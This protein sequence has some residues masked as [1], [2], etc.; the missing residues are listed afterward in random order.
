MDA[1]SEHLVQKA[2]DELIKLGLQTVICIAHRLSTIRDADVIMVMKYGEIVER[3]SH[4]ELM[5]IEDGVYKALIS[6]QLQGQKN[7]GLSATPVRESE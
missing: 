1:E 6:R 5:Q 3:G 2:L 4:N 7:A